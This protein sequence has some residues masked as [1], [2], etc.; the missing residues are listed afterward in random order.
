MVLDSGDGVSHCVPV[1]EGFALPHAVLRSDVAGRDVTEH[2]LLQLRRTGHVFHTS[3]EREVVRQIKEKATG[4]GWLVGLCSYSCPYIIKFLSMLYC[5]V[6]VLL[7]SL[8][9][10]VIVVCVYVITYVFFSF[11]FRSATWR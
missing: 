11:Y 5:Y 8:F 1:Y 3:A 4:N 10:L 7:L 2:L 6:Y 9:I